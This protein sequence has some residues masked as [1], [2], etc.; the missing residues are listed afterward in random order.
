MFSSTAVLEKIQ[1]DQVKQKLAEFIPSIS[2]GATTMK[3]KRNLIGSEQV[4]QWD[5][6]SLSIVSSSLGYPNKKPKIKSSHVN[7]SW[8]KEG[9]TINENLI[10]LLSICNKRVSNHTIGSQS[11]KGSFNSS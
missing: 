9:D 11:Q 8:F 3:R 1:N 7:I 4:D 6:R 2:G 5:Q 10:L